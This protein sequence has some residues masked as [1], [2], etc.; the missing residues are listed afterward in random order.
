MGEHGS[1]TIP[2][3]HYW[4]LPCVMVSDEGWC[5]I[6]RLHFELSPW[7][8]IHYAMC[9]LNFNYTNHLKRLDFN[10]ENLYSIFS[11]FTK[12]RLSVSK[13]HCGDKW[14]CTSW[15]CL[16]KGLHVFHWAWLFYPLILSANSDSVLLSPF[17]LP[18][19]CPSNVFPAA[20]SVS[21]SS[22]WEHIHSVG[23]AS[24]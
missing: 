10:K 6:D 17:V 8:K 14:C 20:P 24:D 11:W 1:F 2:L 16:Q 22:C 19:F 23:G 3:M 5:N 12:D 15:F 9:A 18:S 21:L 13:V 4:S 7:L